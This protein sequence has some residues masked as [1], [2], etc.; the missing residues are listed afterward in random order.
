M[1][2]CAFQKKADETGLISAEDNHRNPQEG[3][4]NF[5]PAFIHTKRTEKNG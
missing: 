4:T 2:H 5:G 1:S 3:F